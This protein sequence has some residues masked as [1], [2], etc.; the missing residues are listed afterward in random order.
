MLMGRNRSFRWALLLLLSVLRLHAFHTPLPDVE[1]IRSVLTAVSSDNERPKNN[2]LLLEELQEKFSYEG[3]LPTIPNFRCGFVSII[4]APNMGKSTLLNALLKEDLCIATARPQT[5]RHAVLGLLT[6]ATH[7]VCLVDTPG[8]IANPAYKLQEGM[9]EAV[10]SAV[11]DAD[12]LMVVTDLFSTPIPD[13]KLFQRIQTTPKPVV[14]VINKIDLA[15]KVRNKEDKVSTT[16]EEA[17]SLWRQLVPNAQCVIPVTAANG[18]EDPGVVAVRNLLTSNT[19]NMSSSLRNLGR[20]IVGMFRKGLDYTT[21]SFLPLPLS[22]PLYDQEALT[23]RTERFVAS[24][25]IR[26]S[27]F[28]L[29]KQELPYCCEVR[30]TKFKDKKSLDSI[31]AD[32]IVERESQKVIVIGKKGAQIKEIGILARKKLEEFLQTKVYLDL[33][34]RVDKDWR[35]NE[36]SLKS[37]GYLL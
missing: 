6:T 8:V 17:V 5:T 26:A 21:E 24:E 32:V 19:E 27:L 16:A 31:A 4:G 20:P 13:D 12:I 18:P 30:I 35:K 7:Q 37:F 1:R 36:D 15:E 33:R 9:M 23:D 22:P 3:R 28:E 11:H 10:F 34:V 25:L 2:D 29:L 14:V